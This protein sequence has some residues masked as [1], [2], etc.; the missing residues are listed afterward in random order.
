MFRSLQFAASLV[1]TFHRSHFRV[2]SAL[3]NLDSRQRLLRWKAPKTILFHVQGL[4]TV[5]KLAPGLQLT[6]KVIHLCIAHHTRLAYYTTHT[7]PLN[8]IAQIQVLYKGPPG[9]D[10]H[11]SFTLMMDNGAKVEVP[12]HALQPRSKVHTKTGPASHAQ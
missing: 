2:W 8:K 9:H 4:A 12:C 1:S 11:D 10:A 3:Q 7:H 6:F 5:S